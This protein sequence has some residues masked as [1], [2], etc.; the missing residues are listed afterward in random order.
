MLNLYVHLCFHSWFFLLVEIRL[1]QSLTPDKYIVSLLCY[2][3]H[4]FQQK[5]KKTLGKQ[6]E[7]KTKN[8]KP[9]H[10]EQTIT[11]NVEPKQ[12]KQKGLE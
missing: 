6:D 3:K 10:L 2:L 1:P 8:Q 11:K 4:N 9:K 5:T 12:K 7:T